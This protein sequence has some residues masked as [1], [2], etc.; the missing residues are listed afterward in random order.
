VQCGQRGDAVGTVS[1]PSGQGW[2][3]PGGGVPGKSGAR[4]PQKESRGAD[5]AL[6]VMVCP[7]RQEKPLANDITPPVPHTD[8]GG[9]G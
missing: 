5:E 7:G 2:L 9:Q 1:H 3:A 8:T 4:I 6:V